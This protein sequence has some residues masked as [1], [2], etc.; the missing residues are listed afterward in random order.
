MKVLYSGSRDELNAKL[1]ERDE[2]IE[3]LSKDNQRLAGA[4]E[5]AIA[6]DEC[7]T[8]QEYEVAMD[9]AIVVA[10]TALQL[11]KGE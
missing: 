10:R 9:E 6:A 1:Q 5:K 11:H 3:R 8:R 7:A 2:T 4:L